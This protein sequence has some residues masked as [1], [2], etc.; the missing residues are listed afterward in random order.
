VILLSMTVWLLAIAFWQVEKGALERHPGWEYHH[1]EAGVASLLRS[2][3]EKTFIQLQ[4]CL[5][6]ELETDCIGRLVT[7]ARHDRPWSV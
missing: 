6:D 4:D 1:F 5:S 7:S 2:S 3:Y